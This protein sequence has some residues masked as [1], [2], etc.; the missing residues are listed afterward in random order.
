M[1]GQVRIYE[2]VI[3]DPIAEV[4]IGKEVKTTLF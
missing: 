2:Y 1:D 4:N 3:R